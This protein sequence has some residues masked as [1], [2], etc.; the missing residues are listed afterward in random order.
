MKEVNLKD[1]CL[2]NAYLR[3][4]S[5][6]YV[7]LHGTKIAGAYMKGASLRGKEIDSEIL[8]YAR[9]RGAI[10]HQVV[11][12]EHSTLS[13]RFAQM[14]SSGISDDLRMSFSV[15]SVSKADFNFPSADILSNT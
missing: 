14:L 13:G 11:E 2:E 1:A 6:D 10:S 8:S 9:M 3:N 12:S 7:I 5:L 15:R 4:A